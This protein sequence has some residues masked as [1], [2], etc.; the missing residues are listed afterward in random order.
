[1]DNPEPVFAARNVYIV[2]RPR[3]FKDAHFGFGV[4]GSKGSTLRGVA[5]KMA[6]R[7]P[8]RDRAIDIAFKV[9]WNSFGG[10]RSLQIELV[11]WK[12]SEGV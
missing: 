5:W 9:S 11:D 1:M 10:R 3:I 4:E 7:I 12:L 6:D 8:P 2:G